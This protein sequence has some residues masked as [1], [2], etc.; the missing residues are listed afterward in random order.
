[1][2]LGRPPDILYTASPSAF[3]NYAVTSENFSDAALLGEL[4]LSL[5]GAFFD[6]VASRDA[7][8]R[9]ARGTTSLTFDD[10]QDLTRVV[11]GDTLADAGP[12]AG[13]RLLGGVRYAKDFTIDPYFI[14]FPT[15]RFSGT[16]ATPS[17]A[18]VYVNG[19]LVRTLNL[20]PGQFNLQDL[21]A[22]VGSGNTRV[23]IRNA[24][25]QQQVLGGPLYIS[26]QVLREG[27]E[28]WSYSAGFERRSLSEDF[29]SYARPAIVARHR[30]GL[31]DTV[32]PGGFFN[33]DSHLIG[34]GPELALALPVGQLGLFAGGSGGVGS[35]G[36]AGS[37]TYAY[38]SPGFGIGLDAA[39]TSQHFGGIGLA[40]TD[41][42]ATLRLDGFLALPIG[43]DSVVAQ[44]SHA[45]FR[46]AGRNDLASVSYTTRL[47]EA[48]DLSLTL[49]QNRLQ[50]TPVDTGVFVSLTIPF[51]ERRTATASVS[52]DS[53]GTLGTLQ[54]QQALPLGEGFGYLTQLQAGANAARLANGIYQ[55]RYGRY[56]LDLTQAAGSV[57]E[58]AIVSG[59]VV[60]IGDGVQL[61]RPI[62]DAYALI[63]VP[64]VAGV[65]GYVSNQEI[66]RTDGEGE[67]FLPDL[68]S[69]FGNRIAIEDQD[70]PIE[71][72]IAATE[73]VV[74]PPFHG[75]AV[76]DF[77]VRRLQVYAGT[78]VVEAGGEEIVPRYG[79]L[80]LAVAGKPVSSPIGAGGE[81]YFDTIEPG[82]YDAVISY[83]EGRCRFGFVAP[84]ASEQFVRMG[85]LT[86]R[87]S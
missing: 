23:V 80:T 72:G 4:G 9:F 54:A 6:T 61:S 63:R 52:H 64:G 13:A 7:E 69:Y 76:I 2:A 59:S 21:P 56:E 29:G 81:F 83:A 79:D 58:T 1:L 78:V 18:D 48:L 14:P 36:Y 73:R 68:Q 38:Q 41:D 62:R 11:L 46:D 55:G 82:R 17:I 44:I 3:L 86:C 71:Y 67:L 43:R 31:T 22:T 77:P 32:T 28:Q 8:G 70:V 65:T 49:S 20:P 66:G 27:L 19:V 74:A 85:K 37:A 39:Y 57:H 42:R 35:A 53:T 87:A 24:F 45:H 5:G 26:P 16:V 10:R 60:A 51:G 33:A 30:Y 84:A 34:G 15:G 50:G 75:G 25:G 47:S 12:L 40:P